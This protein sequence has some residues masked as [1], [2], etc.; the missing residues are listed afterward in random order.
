MKRLIL[1]LALILSLEK[2]GANAQSVAFKVGNNPTTIN[3]SA[4]LDIESTTKGFLPPR[5]TNAQMTAITSPAKGLIVYCTDCTTE[6]IMQNTG[7]PVAPNWIALGSTANQNSGDCPTVTT[8]CNIAGFTGTFSATLN[9]SD[10]VYRVTLYNNTFNPTTIPFAASDLVLSSTDFSVAGLVVGTPTAVPALTSGSI[11]LA[12]GQ[13]VVV[14]YPITGTVPGCGTLTGAW[15]KVSLSCTKTITVN[16]IANCSAGDWVTYITPSPLG[17]L[18]NGTSYSGSYSIPITGGACNLPPDNFTVNNITFSF[19]GGTIPSNGNLV[20]NVTTG[21]GG[22]QGNTGRF[23]FLNTTLGGGCRVVLGLYTSCN[24][25]EVARA[26]AP[27]GVY[28]IDPDGTGTAFSRMNAQCD[29]TTDGGGWTLIVNYM[30]QGS[31]SASPTSRATLPIFGSSTLG[32]NEAGHPQFWGHANQNLLNLM[33]FSTIRY[34]GRTSGHSRVMDFKTSATSHIS[35]VKSLSANQAASAYSAIAGASSASTWQALPGHNTNLPQSMGGFLNTGTSFTVQGIHWLA[36]GVNPF[37]NNWPGHNPWQ[38]G[39]FYH[40]GTLFGRWEMDD[41][42]DNGAN[43][44]I[45]RIWVR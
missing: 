18:V 15:K 44:T 32:A 39:G 14:T 22:Y 31:T 40:F 27:D 2:V 34:T 41:A 16:P 28:P 20:Y 11:T 35:A 23:E 38:S 43:H 7:T 24:G 10:R 19:A 8:D 25:Y 13:S 42:P 45:H 29:M 26:D 36:G 6:G 21:P 3:T 4:A 30:H 5:M 33:P 12:A 9:T 17:G 1:I 37:G